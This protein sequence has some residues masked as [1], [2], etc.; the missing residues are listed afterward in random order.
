MR[1]SHEENSE[2]WRWTMSFSLPKW[3]PVVMWYALVLFVGGAGGYLVHA[4]N[5]AVDE[6]RAYDA[7]FVEGEASCNAP[8]RL[9][10][11]TKAFSGW[12]SDR[13]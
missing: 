3:V 11:G 13:K 8:T 6:N 10:K 1:T 12:L 2:E 7:G 5:V 9:E 4:T